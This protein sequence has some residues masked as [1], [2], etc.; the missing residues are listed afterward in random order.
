[1]P[2]GSIVKYREPT[3]LEAY[4]WQIVAIIAALLLQSAIIGRLLIERR[5]RQRAQV[6]TRKRFS[7][8]AHMN[9]SV[10]LGA[11]SASIA[12]ELNQ[13]L[14]AI[15]NNAGAAEMLI[16]VD[17]PPM[18]EIQDILGDIKRDDQ[19]A[20]AV[21]TRIRALLHKSGFELR[22]VDLNCSVAEAVS[23]LVAEASVRGVELQS[24]FEPSLPPVRAD[25][26]Q[27][28]QVVI[29]LA[30]NGMDAMREDVG[31][32]RTLLVRTTKINNAAAEVSVADNG[33]GIPGDRLDTVFE[34]FYTTKLD[35][36]GLGL[37]IS[38]TI[39]EAHGGVIRAENADRGGA[40]VRFTLPFSLA[41]T[42]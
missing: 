40:I 2:P 12:H 11:L 31:R 20:S 4:G 36:M 16:N 10:A 9:R 34:P 39:V 22:K 29:N 23:F 37:S 42:A 33:P 6:E 19:R 15:L 3:V 1:L 21:I 26:V 32:A 28:Q 8:M 35:G 7:E 18:Q 25:A 24:E 38:R 5:A 13:P 27:V 17:P 41:A 14:G 30:L